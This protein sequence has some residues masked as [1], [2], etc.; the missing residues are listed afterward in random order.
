MFPGARLTDPVTHDTVVPSGLIA[1]PSPG[2]PVTV[3]TEKMPAAVMGDFVLCSGMTSAGPA[4]P[5]MIGPPPAFVPPLPMPP[6]AKGS[7]TVL[8]HGRPAARW[9]VDM[10]GCGTLLGDPKMMVA[11]TVFIG[12]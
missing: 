2:R 3:L 7:A 11:R 8:I 12:G 4:H 1:V 9:I 6:I 5:P 10:A